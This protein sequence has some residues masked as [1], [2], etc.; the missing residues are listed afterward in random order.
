MIADT[1]AAPEVSYHGGAPE[2]ESRIGRK[3]PPFGILVADILGQAFHGLDSIPANTVQFWDDRHCSI[4][5]V[6]E[7]LSTAGNTILSD[8][9]I[10]CHFHHVKLTI[11][12]EKM[13]C[14]AVP[15]DHLHSI[16]K[17][18]PAKINR[19]KDENEIGLLSVV[20]AIKLSFDQRSED[21]HRTIVDA[22]DD[23]LDLDDE[24]A[25]E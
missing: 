5:V 15:N 6:N 20:P 7:Q 9:V 19:L 1:D 18:E 2:I 24:I 21:Q 23:A 10:L 25:D 13:L 11:S 17:Y 3:L 12:A 14:R 4:C 8:L 16:C 22:I